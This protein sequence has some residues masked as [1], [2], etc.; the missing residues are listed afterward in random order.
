M[1]KFEN[2]GLSLPNLGPGVT[3]YPSQ[4]KLL[5]FLIEAG[6][7]G[8][9][10]LDLRY[11]GVPRVRQSIYELRQKGAVIETVKKNV[12]DENDCVRHGIAHYNYVGWNENVVQPGAVAPRK[13]SLLSLVLSKLAEWK[14]R[15]STLL[16]RNPFSTLV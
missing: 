4:E 10:S 12:R 16:K 2:N 3:L 7:L 14:R 5:E 8:M 13:H 1:T 11:L 6:S 15:I 9:S